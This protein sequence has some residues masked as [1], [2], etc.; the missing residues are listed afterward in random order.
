MR[1]IRALWMV[2]VVAFAAPAFAG[3]VVTASMVKNGFFLAPDCKPTADPQ[4]YNECVC[5]ASIKKAQIAGLAAEIV[6]SINSGLSMLPE[7][8]AVE[9]CEGKPTTAPREGLKVN[10]A[11]ADYEIAYQTPTTL[12]VLITYSTYGAGADRALEGTEGFTF[13]LASGQLVDPVVLL[14]PEQ[15]KK[16]DSVI[17]SELLRK[18]P[19]AL[20]DEA[21]KRT[22]PYLTENGCDTCTLFYGKDGWMVRFQIESIAP[23][24]T[25]EP[26]VALS[27]DIIPAPE[28]LIALPKS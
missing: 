20:Y 27:T 18:Y 4:A 25:G 7:K 12:T 10:Q 5:E 2:L 14:K 13:D 11:S 19:A 3:I 15:L 1:L 28:T 9:S 6:A 22:D 16:A 17:K 21:K 23:Y 8:L 24:M 26:E